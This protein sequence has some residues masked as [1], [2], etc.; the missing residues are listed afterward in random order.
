[1]K[2]MKKKILWFTDTI[3]DLNGVSHTLKQIAS[4]AHEKNKN[5]KIVSCYSEDEIDGVLPQ[6]VINLKE[7]FKFKLPA[8]E[9]LK[10]HLPSILSSLKEIYNQNP[11]EIYIS[12]PGPI[13]LLGLLAAKLLKVKAVGVYHTDFTLQSKE[14]IADSRRNAVENYNWDSIINNFVKYNRSSPINNK[15]ITNLL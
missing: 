4:L 11:D 5:I 15:L 10:L 14:I 13:G 7:I 8:Y 12:T 9:K 1:M 3:N 2:K 6:N